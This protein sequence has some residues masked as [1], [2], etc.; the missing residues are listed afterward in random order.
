MIL[1]TNRSGILF[2]FLFL[3]S[4]YLPARSNE[5]PKAVNGVIDLRNWNLARYPVAL[6]GHWSFYDRE[7]TTHP[8]SEARQI[9]FPEVLDKQGHAD[10]QYGTYAIRII[11]PSGTGKLAVEIPHLYSSYKLYIDGKVVAENGKPGTSKETTIPQWDP[12]VVPFDPAHDTLT[13]VLQ[14]ANF[15]HHH[16]GAKQPLYL[17]YAALLEKQY[18][19]ASS[20]NLAECIVLLVLGLSFFV[21]YYVRQ[22]KKKITLY[23]SLLCISWAIRSVFSNNY[24][25]IDY[26]PQFNWAW[27]VRIEYITLYSM[28][29]WAVL[30][31]SRL[32]PRE[33]SRIIKYI[34]VSIN[35]IFILETLFTA[36][37]FFTQWI[38]VY[39]IVAALL[40]IHSA[41]ITMRAL[42]NERAGVWYLVFSLVL[43]LLLF[44]YDIAVFEGYFQHYDALLFSL[45]YIII[46]VLMAIALFYHLRIFRGDGTAGTL[47]FDDLYGTETVRERNR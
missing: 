31:F 19:N 17:G 9:Y 10:S 40:L 32:F 2:A 6:S 28:L 13:A 14:V 18:Q 47:T 24:L 22:E 29:I 16:T 45:G 42:L 34:L 33:S 27:M 36:P 23:F 38:Y 11:L 30:F 39:L 4:G 3:I 21:I 15:Y 26:F 25:I 44:T 7:L 8:H 37:A 12:K 35:C 46:F 1:L 20:S 5:P 41:V 43:G